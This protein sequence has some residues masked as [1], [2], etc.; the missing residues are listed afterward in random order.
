MTEEKLIKEQVFQF[1]EQNGIIP[2]D[3]NMDFIMDGQL[4]RFSVEGDKHGDKSG[5]YV[6]HNDE[7]PAWAVMDYHKTDEMIKGKFNPDSLRTYER[8][9]FFTQLR[10]L[11]TPQFQSKKT[12]ERKRQEQHQEKMRAEAVNR[13][14]REYNDTR[15]SCADEHPYSQLK[16]LTDCRMFDYQAR[17]KTN[18]REGDYGQI[19]DLMIPLHN[20]ETGRFQSM[21]LIRGNPNTE[22]KYQKGIYKDTQVTGACFSLIPFE[23]KK[24]D[25][26]FICEGVATAAS[27]FKALDFE[28]EVIAAMNCHN[29]INVARAFKKKC[30]DRIIIIAAD[31][32]TAGIK[33]AEK[34]KEAGYADKIILPPLS[35]E[36][37]KDWNDYY[38]KEGVI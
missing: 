27:L 36:Q 22:G 10:K 12:D 25:M 38:I 6:I 18:R 21:Q 23:D 34:T 4:H 7:W 15:N 9:E 20:A 17:I 26:L 37:G 3:R 32:D 1:M 2:R 31:N 30:S 35:P 28:V 13:A 5:A 11:S 8:D 16:H 33:T 19:G 14:W 29:I 24:P